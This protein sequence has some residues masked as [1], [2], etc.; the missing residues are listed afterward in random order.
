MRHILK[1][2]LFIL[3]VSSFVQ[4]ATAQKVDLTWEQL[5]EVTFEQ[6]YQDAVGSYVNIPTFSP[7]LNT[8]DGKEVEISGYVIPVDIE[9]GLYVLSANPFAN[10]FFCGNAGPES[11]VELEFKKK[12]KRFNTDDFLRFRGK[13]KLNKNDIYRL[14][15]ILTEAVLID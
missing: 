15:Y 7:K 2:T 1:I 5:S 8:L 4:S 10:C 13:L 6:K 12:Q 3:L 11:V 14:N 9:Q